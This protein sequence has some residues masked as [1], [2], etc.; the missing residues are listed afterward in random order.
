MAKK[1]T[2][3]AEETNVNDE[4]ERRDKLSPEAYRMTTGEG[5]WTDSLSLEFEAASHG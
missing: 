3:T 2:S 1:C 4:Q 5:Y